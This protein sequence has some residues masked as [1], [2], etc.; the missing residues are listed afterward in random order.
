M[1]WS[2][3]D[4][5]EVAEALRDF[6]EDVARLAR[7]LCLSPR[8]AAAVWIEF[9]EEELCAA[10]YGLDP[11]DDVIRADARAY[12]GRA[13]KCPDEP[14][15]PATRAQDLLLFGNAFETRDGVRIPPDEFR[16]FR[17]AAS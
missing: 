5:A 13:A 12:L 3:H 2:E 14:A 15:T 4:E 16:E 9:S 1:S 10:W 17:E 11:S 6:P 7:V 8:K